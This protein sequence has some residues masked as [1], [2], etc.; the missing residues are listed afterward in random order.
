MLLPCPTSALLLPALSVRMAEPLMLPTA[1]SLV[2]PWLDAGV[3]F[4]FAACSRHSRESVVVAGSLFLTDADCNDVDRLHLQFPVPQE[5]WRGRRAISFRRC[6]SET[7]L[8]ENAASLEAV[9][10]RQFA[11]P[12]RLSFVAPFSPQ[13][14][15]SIHLQ[16]CSL[17]LV[18]LPPQL[19]HLKIIDCRGVFPS[20][21]PCAWSLQ[22]LDLSRCKSQKI[23]F[24]LL[25]AS[26]PMC[27][28]QLCSFAA[29]DVALADRG[30]SRRLLAA[31]PASRIVRLELRSWRELD[32]SGADLPTQWPLIRHADLSH[33]DGSVASLLL[34]TFGRSSLRCIHL[35]NCGMAHTEWCPMDA[36]NDCSQLEVLNVNV[37]RPWFLPVA[38]IP[39]TSLTSFLAWRVAAV[40]DVFLARLV[41]CCPH[42]H[43]L[44]LAETSVSTVGVRLLADSALASGLIQTNFSCIRLGAADVQRLL[45]SS[46]SSLQSIGL[47]ATEAG[48][49][50]FE[51]IGLLPSLESIDVT[52]NPRLTVRGLSLLRQ[53]APAL[54]QL[55]ADGVG[56]KCH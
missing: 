12:M 43:T 39:P 54:Q 46:R 17:D 53:H 18:V 40:D 7:L 27:S 19:Q 2:V 5:M 3:L 34:R 11:E 14:L 47:S 29:N 24:T 45:L 36:L 52:R 38:F 4:H 23:D 16:M 28:M 8:R 33:C 56:A 32:S 10:V 51:G 21:Q 25:L 13:H 1:F 37:C 55:L 41:S 31:L 9:S 15:S 42:L 48:D 6:W 50:M 20:L 44:D 26:L 35:W 30:D 49:D 22:S